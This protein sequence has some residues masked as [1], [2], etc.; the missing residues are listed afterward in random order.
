MRHLAA[1]TCLLF[2]ACGGPGT[3]SPVHE[4]R[5]APDEDH[6]VRFTN[7][8]QVSLTLYAVTASG[9]TRICRAAVEQT[10]TGELPS[11]A[12]GSGNR[13]AWLMRFNHSRKV[14]T[15]RDRVPL[16]GGYN[17]IMDGHFLP[18]GLDATVVARSH[19]PQ[20]TFCYDSD[21]CR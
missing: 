6:T 12:L 19:R 14:Y 11:V 20:S 16:S 9:P 13:V 7:H 1:L 18:P 3:P 8:A 10:C 4:H 21:A 15:A 17:Y 2:L 5:P